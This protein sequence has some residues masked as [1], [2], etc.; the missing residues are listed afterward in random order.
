MRVRPSSNKP[1]VLP[2][3]KGSRKYAQPRAKSIA[4][5]GPDQV[6]RVR[7][8]QKIMYRFD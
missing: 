4:Y 7:P 5:V 3:Q 1:K 6:L 8:R 2:A